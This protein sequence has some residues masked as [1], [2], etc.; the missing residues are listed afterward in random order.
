[1]WTRPWAIAQDRRHDIV[2][3]GEDS[4]ADLDRFARRA[5][6]RKTSAVN[7]RLNALDDNA[8]RQCLGNVV[9]RPLAAGRGVPIADC[10]V[11]AIVRRLTAANCRLTTAA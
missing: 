7:L 5:L 8:A 1:M 10:R 11:P 9:R 4:G 6:D 3:V 2:A